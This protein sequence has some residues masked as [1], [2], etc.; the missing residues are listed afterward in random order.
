MMR[1]CGD[2]MIEIKGKYNTAKVFTNNVEPEAMAQ[3]LE[4]CN[5]EFVKDSVSELCLIPMPVQVVP[6]EPP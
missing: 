2:F 1:K 4:L 6:L 5:Q 3:I